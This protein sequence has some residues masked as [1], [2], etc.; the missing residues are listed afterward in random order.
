MKTSGLARM[1]MMELG[2]VKAGRKIGGDGQNS[3]CALHVT[4][5][6]FTL[7]FGVYGIKEIQQGS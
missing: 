2:R 5:I 4:T 1:M 3:V 7:R 6:R